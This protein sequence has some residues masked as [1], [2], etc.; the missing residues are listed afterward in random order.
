MVQNNGLSV[1]IVGVGKSIIVFL[2]VDERP[3]GRAG[4]R[5]ADEKCR[6]ALASPRPRHDRRGHG[7]VPADRTWSR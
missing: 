2:R 1:D 3:E 7:T 5:N 6:L 4:N